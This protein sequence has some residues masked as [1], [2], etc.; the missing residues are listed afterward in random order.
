MKLTLGMKLTET[1]RA[2]RHARD[3][4]PYNL[5]KLRLFQICRPSLLQLANTDHTQA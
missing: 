1:D 4:M 5:A 3:D 2:W